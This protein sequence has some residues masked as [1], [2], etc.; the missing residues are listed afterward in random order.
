MAFQNFLLMAFL[1]FL[2]NYMAFLNFL[3][4]YKSGSSFRKTASSHIE[5]CRKTVRSCLRW[6]STTV[7]AH[8][9]ARQRAH[10]LNTAGR[11]WAAVCFWGA[12]ATDCAAKKRGNRQ[13]ENWKYQRLCV[14]RG[15]WHPETRQWAWQGGG[16]EYAASCAEDR[17]AVETRSQLQA[18]FE[19]GPT[20]VD[21]A[22]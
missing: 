2:L 5:H 10:T 13:R 8:H 11:Q 20:E 18:R 7:Q 15:E 16:W 22:H 1:N 21:P 19:I 9:C 12:G 17:G 4:D 14:W 6:S 3:L